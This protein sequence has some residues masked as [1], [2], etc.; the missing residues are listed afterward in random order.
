L[1]LST[2][3][4]WT[5]V[6][7]GLAPEGGTVDWGD[8]AGWRFAE[9][10]FDQTV[11]RWAGGSE[12]RL[13]RTDLG[14]LEALDGA[15]SLDPSALIFHLSRCGS[16]LVSRLLAQ[17][18]GTLVIVEPRPVNTLLIADPAMLD[19]SEAARLLRLLVRAL[20]RRRFED[21]RHYVLK[22][23]SWNVARLDLFRRAFPGVPLIWVQRAPAEV[24]AS[25]QADPPGWSALS[26]M[27]A[28]QWLF[29]IPAGEAATLDATGFAARALATLLAK[30]QTAE[31]LTVIDYRELPD[32]IWTR[33]APAIGLA[34]DA[35]DIARLREEARYNAKD[36]GR[37]LFG[38][39]PA[40]RPMLPEPLRRFCAERLEPLYRVL[41]ARRERAP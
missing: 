35:T 26:R 37:R 7:L 20:G 14:A 33:L 29:G 4:R 12:A 6:A 25:T 41:D 23:S 31:E 19:E 39:D 27:P 40:D 15:P 36:P 8:L 28:T 5:P 34:P 10:F 17:L 32:A 9:P 11:D 21:E 13:V 1:D 16:T 2:L 24:L 38:G 22:L 3:A 30:A 18:P